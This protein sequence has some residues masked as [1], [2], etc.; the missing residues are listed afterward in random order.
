MQNLIRL[1]RT[2]DGKYPS[3]LRSR[4]LIEN[5]YVSVSYTIHGL[6]IVCMTVSSVHVT[7]SEVKGTFQH[8]VMLLLGVH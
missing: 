2:V 8:H 3:L 5:P 6:Y 7:L 1:C 4:A